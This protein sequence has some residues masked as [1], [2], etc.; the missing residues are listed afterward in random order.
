MP[1]VHLT[2]RRQERRPAHQPARTGTAS[3]PVGKSV[4]GNG[5]WFYDTNGK[6]AR[7]YSTWSP[8]EDWT[9]TFEAYIQNTRGEL[10]AAKAAELAGKFE[11]IDAFLAS[12]RT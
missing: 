11:I 10:P 3:A 4:S 2:G 8:Y 5:A 9:T 12:K 6:F 1:H 7:D